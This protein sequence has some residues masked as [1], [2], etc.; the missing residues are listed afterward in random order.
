M[1]ADAAG[2]ACSS[3]APAG[4]TSASR[5]PA[6]IGLPLIGT[7]DWNDGMNRVGEGGQG[8]SVWLGWLLL[9]DDR[10]V[11]AAGRRPRPGRARRWRAHAASLREALEREAWDGEW[12]RRATYDDGTWL[13]SKDSGECRIDSH[14]AVVGRPVGRRRSRRAPPRRWRRWTS[15]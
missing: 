2:L 3:I 5:S 15:S 9:R 13:G 14:R 12:Y 7:G 1:A 4:S 6:S 8:E 10:A 11:R